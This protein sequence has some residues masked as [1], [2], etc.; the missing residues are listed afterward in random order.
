MYLSYCTL[1]IL[2]HRPFIEKEGGEKTKS[3]LSSLSIC[4]SA[5]TRCVDVAAS[6]HF[7]DFL[8]VSWNFAIYHVFTASLIH[9]HTVANSGSVVS[10]LAKGI[11][12]KPS[13]S[14]S[15]YLTSPRQHV[16]S[17]KSSCA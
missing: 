5:A 13:V 9:I 11:S 4:T 2:L 10:D 6:M 12:S 15:A 17:I 1:L 14:S 8:L 3:S 16:K 7:R